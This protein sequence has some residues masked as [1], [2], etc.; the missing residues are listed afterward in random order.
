MDTVHTFPLNQDVIE[1][2]TFCLLCLV[3][4]IQSAVEN[5]NE[6]TNAL[7]QWEKN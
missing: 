4:Q 5:K 6:K 1:K 7:I 3:E 2:K